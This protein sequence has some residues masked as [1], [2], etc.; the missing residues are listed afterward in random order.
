M[1][2]FRYLALLAT[3]LLAGCVS[4]PRDSEEAFRESRL[5]GQ[6][7]GSILIVGPEI[8]FTVRQVHGYT[9]FQ[10]LVSGGKVAYFQQTSLAGLG[11]KGTF[12]VTR[13]QM[14]R[15]R[16]QG[17]SLRVTDTSIKIEFTPAYL[18]GFLRRV[19]SVSARAGAAPENAIDR[20]LRRGPAGVDGKSRRR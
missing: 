3:C 5:V 14:E 19:D 11:D 1:R 17:T 18:D 15:Y 2:L 13:A 7:D 8:Q 4:I 12:E 20:P 6:P 10:A 16:T 9:C